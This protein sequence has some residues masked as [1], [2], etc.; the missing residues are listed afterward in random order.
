MPSWEV[1]IGSLGDASVEA[2]RIEHPGEGK[3]SSES[4]EGL[5]FDGEMDEWTWG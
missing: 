1:L 2:E 3:I 4:E 5:E